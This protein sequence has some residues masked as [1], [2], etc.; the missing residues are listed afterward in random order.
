MPCA[1]IYVDEQCSGNGG[2]LI[3]AALNVRKG[4]VEIN[5]GHVEITIGGAIHTG[6]YGKV[7]LKE[8]CARESAII[9]FAEEKIDVMDFHLTRAEIH[10]I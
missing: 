6:L 10:R 8:Y 9:M 4:L 1:R 5:S 2:L 7:Y 3:S